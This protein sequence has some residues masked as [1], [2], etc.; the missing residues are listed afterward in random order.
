MSSAPNKS[1]RSQEGQDT[2]LAVSR[3]QWWLLFMKMKKPS[4]TNAT[5]QRRFVL[6]KIDPLNK[7]HLCIVFDLL[8]YC[9][10]IVFRLPPKKLPDKLFS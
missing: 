7:S 2:L 5:D 6:S 4:I 10:S 8:F 9:Y 3:T 1:Q